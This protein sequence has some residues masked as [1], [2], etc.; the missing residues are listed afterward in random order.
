MIRSNIHE[1]NRRY[2]FY[3]PTRK[4]LLK[5]DGITSEPTPESRGA[6]ADDNVIVEDEGEGLDAGDDIVAQ[7]N[8]ILFGLVPTPESE[9][10]I[11]DGSYTKDELKNQF[12]LADKDLSAFFKKDGIFL[13]RDNN[14]KTR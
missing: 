1:Y 10:P 4:P 9:L 13:R 6:V 5:L 3:F 7:N 11:D 12:G 14:S 8:M 2:P